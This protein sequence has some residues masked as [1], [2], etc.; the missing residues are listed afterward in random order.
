MSEPRTETHIEPRPSERLADRFVRAL[1]RLILR[2]FFRKLEVAGTEKIPGGR[3]L[4]V[5]ANHVNGLLDPA[6]IVGPLPIT[7]RFLGKSTLWKIPAVRP[8]LELAQVI[9][10][11]RRQDLE[12]GGAPLDAEAFARQNAESF[13]QCHEVLAQGGSIAIFPEGKSHNQPALQP[14]KTGAA[15]IVL[16]AQAKYPDLRVWVLPVG[17]LFDAKEKFRSRAFVQV[18]EPFDPSPD[19]PL[20]KEDGP[21]AVRS[22]T[23]RIDKALKDV[24]V[25]YASWDEARLIARAAELWGRPTLEMPKGRRMAESTEIQRAI[26][27]GYQD[28]QTRHPEKVAAVLAAVR[29]YDDLLEAFHLRDAQVAAAYPPSPV[30]RFVVDSLA[31]F[32]F[33]LPLAA[34]GTVLNA[35]PYGILKLFV[36]PIAKTPDQ[37]ATYKVFGALIFYPL[38]WVTTAFLAA[39]YLAPAL[40]WS[41]WGLALAVLVAGPLTGWAALLFHEHRR[42]FW[43]EARAYLVLRTRKRL[44]QELRERREEVVRG[45]GELAGLYQ[46]A[47]SAGRPVG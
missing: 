29:E 4:L 17:L 9:P 28:L 18:G 12:K 13:A 24:T 20:Y 10:V 39:R 8:F 43:R 42:L 26:M 45:V 22:L 19:Y 37:M 34:V 35:L 11:Q 1:V 44:A 21:A 7:P 32:L 14:M 33:H 25:N 31:E 47:E 41:Q 16:E 40:G 30:V 2:V 5:V 15:R 46:T 6:L 38:T 3:P 23:G 27:E 36:P